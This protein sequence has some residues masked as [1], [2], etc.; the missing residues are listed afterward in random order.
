[1]PAKAWALPRSAHTKFTVRELVLI[2][3][4]RRGLILLRKSRAKKRAPKA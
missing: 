1:M 2:E 4:Y 3:A